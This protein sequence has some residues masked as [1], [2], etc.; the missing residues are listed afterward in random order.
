[1]RAAVRLGGETLHLPKRQRR[2]QPLPLL[3]LVDI[4]GSMERYARLL[5]AFLHAATHKH[6]RRAVFAFGTQ[7]TDLSTAF[8][9]AD[10]DAMLAHANALIEDFAGG[11]QLGQS[12]ESLR[13]H[14]ARTLVGRRTLVLVI[15]DGLDTGEPQLLSKELDWL[16][17]HTRRILWL[18]PLLRFD[19]YAPLAQG[20]Q[21]LNQV[22]HGMVAI[23]NLTKLEDL[24]SSL[25]KLMKQ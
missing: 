5:L 7:L 12:L 20:A 24:A 23:H 1:M 21:A 2:Q 25:A 6:P 16:K 22:A 4:S 18:N 8:K 9:L 19:G 15:T 3:I 13:T 14:H 11:T 17:L 10:T